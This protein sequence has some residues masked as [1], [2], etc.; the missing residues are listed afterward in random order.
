GSRYGVDCLGSSAGPMVVLLALGAMS[1]T[2]M[3]VATVLVFAERVG[4]SLV[5]PI[6][7][8]LIGLG[9]WVALDPSAVPGLVAPM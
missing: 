9:L 1:V 5:V 2:W 8:V 3:V 6:A 4:S 7:V